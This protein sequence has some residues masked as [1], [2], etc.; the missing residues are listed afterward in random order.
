[1]WI[2]AFTDRVSQF[3]DRLRCDD[4]HRSLQLHGFGPW[5][6]WRSRGQAHIETIVS[7][8]PLSPCD[9]AVLQQ[10]YPHGW[11]TQ[12]EFENILCVLVFWCHITLLSP[13]NHIGIWAVLHVALIRTIRAWGPRRSALRQMCP[14]EWWCW[15]DAWACTTSRQPRACPRAGTSWWDICHCPASNWSGPC[16]T[17]PACC[18]I[19][20][21]WRGARCDTC[22]AC[23]ACCD[24]CPA[25]CPASCGT[26]CDTCPAC[27]ACFAVCCD[28][29]PAW[30]GACLVWH[31]SS[32]VWC[33]L[34]HLSTRWCV[35]RHLSSLPA[36]GAC[37][38]IC[39]AWSGACCDIC[40][41]CGACC[42]TCAASC[43]TWDSWHAS[44]SLHSCSSFVVLLEH[45]SLLLSQRLLPAHLHMKMPCLITR[46]T[47]ACRQMWKNMCQSLLK[48][49]QIHAPSAWRR[50]KWESRWQPCPVHMCVTMSACQSG[51]PH[52]RAASLCTTARWGVRGPGSRRWNMC[53]LSGSLWRPKMRLL[54][55]PRS[56]RFLAEVICL[57]LWSKYH[58]S[59][60]EVICAA[61]FCG[62]VGCILWSSV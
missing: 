42:D 34:S 31:L 2:Y 48:R 37:C 47:T 25:T 19:C 26:W 24:I 58:M 45:L 27:P 60:G 29:C 7:K 14:Q 54:W 49:S 28:I 8:L 38:D 53:R 61:C 43:A 18:D 1:M 12:N 51:G 32:L 39:R 6:G 33:L 4:I 44:T 57:L 36:C 11:D 3:A 15:S 40:P 23:G 5:N 22:P 62:A 30:G 9:D 50:S 17:C 41:A 10:A 52:V 16:D 55:R 20:A 35:L 56:S 13:K 46:V 21:A 59:W